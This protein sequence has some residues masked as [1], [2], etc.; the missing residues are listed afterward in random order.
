MGDV[1]V[2]NQPD[3]DALALRLTGAPT[4]EELLARD[5]AP[6]L[7][8]SRNAARRVPAA[9]DRV[10]LADAYDLEQARRGVHLRADRGW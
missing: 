10:T 8:C 9:R 1:N 5:C 7:P 6:E 2:T 4:F 3:L